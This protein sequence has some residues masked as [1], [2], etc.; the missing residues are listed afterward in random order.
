M[1]IRVFE[2]YAVCRCLYYT[3]DVDQCSNYMRRGHAVR[4]R[5]VLVD[6]HV[7]SILQQ[8]FIVHLALELAVK[9]RRYT[10]AILHWK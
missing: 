3:H 1:C 5:E 8:A 2:R 10:K 4:Y 7:L 9:H 6:T